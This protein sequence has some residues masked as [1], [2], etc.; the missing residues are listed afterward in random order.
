MSIRFLCPQCGKKL[1]APDHDAGRSTICSGCGEK[2]RI[3]MADGSTADSVAHRAP[4][5]IDAEHAAL[6]DEGALDPFGLMPRKSNHPEDLIDMT[7]MVDIVFFMLIF[8]MV[9]S[10]QAIVAVM[11]FPPAQ[12]Q[13]GA[14][15]K[16]KSAAD[17]QADPEFLTVRIEAGDEVWIDE[18]QVYGEMA[19]R[20]RLRTERSKDNERRSVL[21]IGN[22]DATHGAA[23]LVFDSCMDAGF[24]DIRLSVQETKD[25]A[26]G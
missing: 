10:A 18:E 26:G 14:A 4:A 11:P 24:D 16:V 5:T 7:A 8:F 22:A 13:S 25:D 15:G 9:A 6:D 19:V 21:V 12:A 17:L 20:T 3:P 23:V 1:K 2:S